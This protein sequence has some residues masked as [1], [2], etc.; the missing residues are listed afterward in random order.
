MKT[1]GE[2]IEKL[3]KFDKGLPIQALIMG[4]GYEVRD[5]RVEDGWNYED[6][7]KTDIV[8]LDIACELPLYIP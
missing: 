6:E 3:E 7:E 2:L 4:G 8:C 5:V 1:V